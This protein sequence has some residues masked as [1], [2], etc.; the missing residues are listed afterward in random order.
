MWVLCQFASY[1]VAGVEVGFLILVG[2]IVVAVL[3]GT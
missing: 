1:F 2:A 3:E